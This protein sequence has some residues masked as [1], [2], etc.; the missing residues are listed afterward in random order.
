MD[1]N[2]T[3]SWSAQ[4]LAYV[5]SEKNQ[6]EIS[7]T[8]GHPQIL[9]SLTCV[10]HHQILMTLQAQHPEVVNTAELQICTMHEN[11][12]P[13]SIPIIHGILLGVIQHAA[14]SHTP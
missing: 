10:L 5:E 6:R 2:N 1:C 13:L 12:V 3:R 11:G 7:K 14:L 8:L 4:T 9:V